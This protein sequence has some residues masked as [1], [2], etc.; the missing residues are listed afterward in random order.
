MPNMDVFN[1]DPFSLHSM[2]DAIN[3]IPFRPGQVGQLGLFTPVP[4]ST[5]HVD[6]EEINGVLKLLPTKERN[7]PATPYTTQKRT[8]RSLRVP[9][10]PHG[11]RIGADEIQGVRAFGTENQLQTIQ[12]VVNDHLTNMGW[13]HDVTLEHLMIGAVKGEILDADGSTILFD[14]FSSFGVS[15]HTEIDFDLD[16]ASPAKG[17]LRK[18]CHDVKRKI[19]DELGGVVLPGIH[20]LCSSQFFDDLVSHTEAATAYERFLN[21]EILR[22]GLAR[23][24]F[25]IFDITFEEYRGTVNGVSFIPDNKAH[26]FPVGVPGLFKVYFAPANY[27]ETVNTLGRPRYAKLAPD[28]KFNKYVEVET[29]SNPLPLCT[30]PRT[31]IKA[32]RT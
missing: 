8:L 2:V 4:I 13:N 18:A 19:Q 9:H 6:I 11:D 10:V 22:T 17:A 1:Q 15:Q 24:R 21:G 12:T 7:A 23:K 32:K 3:K 29:Q 31:L 25:E 26:F 14:L 20:C 5:V 30:R 27:M 28:T 16:N